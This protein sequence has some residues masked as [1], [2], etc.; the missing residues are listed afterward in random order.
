MA[1]PII[2]ETCIIFRYHYCWITFHGETR[3]TEQRER[4][5]FYLIQREAVSS[6]IR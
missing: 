5:I 2:P 6:A 3:E 4:D 1:V